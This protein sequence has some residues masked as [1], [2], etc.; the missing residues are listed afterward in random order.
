MFK[1]SFE[2]AWLSLRAHASL[3]ALNGYML[4]LA[5]K[6]LGIN[7]YRSDSISGE[8]H[9]CRLLMK[10]FR[11]EVIFDV[12]AHQGNYARMVRREGFT[13][14]LFLFEPHPE[15][16]RKLSKGIKADDR[17]HLF[18]IGFSNQEG[19]S[20]LFDYA[21]EKG[22]GSEHASL[23]S[24][25]I[26]DLH[27]SGD[28]HGVKVTLES[29]DHFTEVHGV[30]RI[31]LLKIDTEGNEY[32]ILQGASRLLREGR[33]DLIQF[34]FGEMNVA[35]R[36]FFKDFYDLLNPQYRIY[37]LLPGD[38]LPI[39]RYNARHHEIFVYQNLVAVHRSLE[40]R[41]DRRS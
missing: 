24:E 29:L 32:R 11:P 19:E 1:K 27:G 6:T 31:S 15:S 5:H 10:R 39:G 25:V 16:F 17:T 12:G 8:G 33:I 30:D 3:A 37:R 9:W 21:G 4:H 40:D 35:S 20:L 7:N 23:F 34:E 28:A 26:K 22:G 2:I 38:L 18:H 14:K 36:V 13:G 41:L